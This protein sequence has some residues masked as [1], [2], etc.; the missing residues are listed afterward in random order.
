[1]LKNTTRSSYCI[2]L[3]VITR[4]ARAARIFE[5]PEDVPSQTWHNWAVME[6][7]RR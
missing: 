3:G 4:L 2:D 1:M 6:S 5:T 7:R